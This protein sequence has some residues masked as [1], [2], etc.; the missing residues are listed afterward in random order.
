MMYINSNKLIFSLLTIITSLYNSFGNIC[1]TIPEQQ[2]LL[3]TETSKKY[4]NILKTKL[5]LDIKYKAKNQ[6]TIN[7]ETSALSLDIEGKLIGSKNI[8]LK[9][10]KKV[11]LTYTDNLPLKKSTIWGIM[12]L[13]KI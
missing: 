7:Q 1:P 12:K 4:T 5:L 9:N 11:A 2:E 6:L 3:K 13:I 10:I 8:K